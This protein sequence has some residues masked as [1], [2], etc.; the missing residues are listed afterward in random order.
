MFLL[1]GLGSL[2]FGQ[3]G[4]TGPTNLK[5]RG[6]FFVY[7]GDTLHCLLMD[8]FAQ[9]REESQYQYQLSIAKPTAEE[10]EESDVVDDGD[11][12]SYSFLLHADMRLCKHKASSQPEGTQGFIW[13]APDAT[14]FR[15]PHSPG[16]RTYYFELDDSG[17]PKVNANYFQLS[18]CQC[19]FEHRM[20]RPHDTATNEELEQ[21]CGPSATQSSTS[22]PSTPSPATPVAAPQ[23]YPTLTPP[24]S[25][26]PQRTAPTPSQATYATPHPLSTP[27]H[28]PYTSP[29]PAHATTTT[30]TC[31]VATP[32]AGTPAYAAPTAHTSAH[33]TPAASPAP[34]YATPAPVTPAH[35]T[36]AP[37]T[38]APATPQ[39]SP[40]ASAVSTPSVAA[41]ATPAS[42]GGRAS[43]SLRREQP[44]VYAPPVE[45]G[46]SPAVGILSAPSEPTRQLNV[47]QITHEVPAAE[48]RPVYETMG[49]LFLFN[50]ETQSFE[51]VSDPVRAIVLNMSDSPKVFRYHFLI[52]T[53]EGENLLGQPLCNEMFMHFNEEHRSCIWVASSGDQIVTL[54]LVLGDRLDA[55]RE[56][57]TRRLFEVKR[58]IPFTKVAASDHEWIL[59]AAREVEME[60]ED[61][62]HESDRLDFDSYDED[63]ENAEMD[64]ASDDDE[65]D[66][67]EEHNK[68]LSVG[69]AN[70][71][72]FVVRGSTMDIFR[73]T[74]D[75]ISYLSTVD[76][77]ASLDGTP[78]SPAKMYTHQA[79]R[80]M[81][82]LNP[83]QRSTVLNMDVE[84]GQVVEEWK[85]DEY[86]TPIY[87]IVPETKSAQTSD[88]PT[89]IGLNKQGFFLM[90][91]RVGRNI[92]VRECMVGEKKFMY[93]PT[94]KPGLSCAA[95]TGQGH[96][97][98]GS[99]KGEIRLFD[100]LS[101][102][103]KTQLPGFGDA[104]V[105]IDVTE[106]GKW[107]LA[108]TPT[109]LIIAPT[110][111]PGSSQTRLLTGFT[112]PMGKNKPI[113]RKLELSHE[114]IVRMGGHV[115]FTPA[116]FN[117][118]PM[119]HGGERS[120]VT[121]SGPFVIT[122]NF[123]R[124][125]Q[126][127]LNDYR[128]KRVGE[129]VV[130][131]DFISGQD[132]SIVI[133]TKSNVALEQ[134]RVR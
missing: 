54:S 2:I 115:N 77:I 85:T 27:T 79:D 4:P 87:D 73:N 40:S 105:G 58:Q 69:Q 131:K 125:K 51:P 37:A 82:F 110:E 91:P 56:E 92:A 65:G 71:R 78:F 102:R 17:N 126:N 49:A 97:A 46:P 20:Q 25:A 64:L 62:P 74:R 19:V 3:Q 41:T 75:D 106:D 76:R 55:F 89:F 63:L 96:L 72:S 108:T 13:V 16:F 94:T 14:R 44:V 67:E 70:P 31:A 22:S 88:N 66:E 59:G 43:R 68:L 103:A 36:T 30:T 120:I 11:S 39:A 123:R 23:L 6:K 18:C 113:P 93:A 129:T 80:K 45:A 26:T 1:R 124:V 52:R 99:E 114:D 38:P 28:A 118:D 116:K 112:Q 132:N 5:L 12:S 117:H 42:A 104:I 61:E 107:V 98:V 10:G 53:P 122:W 9:I 109:Y 130:G 47:P 121:T 133:A 8:C 100:S 57:F 95:T 48:G 101:K 35:V 7:V 33:A 128:I 86:G 127:K 84:R 32:T 83:D 15:N 29:V 81:L 34:A 21:F 134:R 50:A 119:H 24:S 90:D 111:L 60:E